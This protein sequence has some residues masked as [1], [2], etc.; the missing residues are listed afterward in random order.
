MSYRHWLLVCSVF[1]SACSEDETIDAAGSGARAGSGGAGPSC[2]LLAA[3]DARGQS[4]RSRRLSAL[5]DRRLHAGVRVPDQRRADP[6]RPGVRQ[7]DRDGR[8]Q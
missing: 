1:A 7:R 8:R 2:D 4:S 3:T 5:R 6:A